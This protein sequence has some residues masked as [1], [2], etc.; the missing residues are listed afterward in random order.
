MTEE[1]QTVVMQK[2]VPFKNLK[3][4]KVQRDHKLFTYEE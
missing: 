4:P 2:K 1:N 3:N